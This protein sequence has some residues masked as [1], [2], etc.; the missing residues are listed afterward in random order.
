MRAFARDQAKELLSVGGRTLLARALADLAAS[1]ITEAL[2]VTSPSKPQIAAAL[3]ARHAGVELQYAVQEEPRGLADALALAEPFARGEPLLCWLPDNLWSGERPASAQLIAALAGRGHDEAHVVAL[4]EVNGREL[5]RFGAAGFVEVAALP[6][7]SDVVRI[8]RV[9]DKGTRP[10]CPP[11]AAL[12]KGF[13]LDLW[14]PD[15]FD[16]IRAQRAQKA[17]GASQGPG[18]GELDDTPLLQALAREGRL[19]GAILR[20]GRL[21]DCGIPAGLE[22]ARAALGG[23]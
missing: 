13:P 10:A 15:L 1:G 18:S 12:F 2:V 20:G 17:S 14:Q 7:T 9:L 19:L 16:R 3:G 23:E 21:F 22:A 11:D 4:L 6:G 5:D 8:D